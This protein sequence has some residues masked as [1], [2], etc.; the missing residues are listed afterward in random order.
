MGFELKR[1]YDIQA[2]KTHYR[3]LVDRL[4]PRGISKET[5]ELDFWAKSLCPSNE[6]RKWFH[7]DKEGRWKE[8]CNKYRDELEENEKEIWD[9]Y[10]K[11]KSEDKVLLLYAGKDE[12]LNHAKVLK[13][14]LEYTLLNK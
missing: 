12:K 14:T 3:V 1:V 10:D 7:G 5:L 13:E 11:V 4:W 9:F 8:F 2:P 6:L